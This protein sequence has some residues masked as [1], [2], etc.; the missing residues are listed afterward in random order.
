MAPCSGHGGGRRPAEACFAVGS[1]MATAEILQNLLVNAQLHASGSAVELA[2]TPVDDQL[3]LT[4]SDRGQA[5]RP[6]LPRRSSPPGTARRGEWGKGSAST[7]ATPGRPG[8]RATGARPTGAARFRTRSTRWSG[9]D[10]FWTPQAGLDAA[11]DLGTVPCPPRLTTASSS[12]RTG[13]GQRDAHGDAGH[14]TYVRAGHRRGQHANPSRE[15]TGQV[16]AQET[17]LDDRATVGAQLGVAST[18]RGCF[19]AAHLPL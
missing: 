8:R 2:V 19:L 4:V 3:V 13:A 9:P 6:M 12:A 10:Q 16:H 5:C 11:H 14:N 18:L 7:S 1:P 15:D 17:G